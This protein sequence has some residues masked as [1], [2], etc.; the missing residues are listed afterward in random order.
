MIKTRYYKLYGGIGNQLF[1]FAH[2]K[3]LQKQGINIKFILNRN[4]FKKPFFDLPELFTLKNSNII[5]PKNKLSLLCSKFYAK[6]ILR[7]WYAGFYQDFAFAQSL[8]DEKNLGNFEFAQKKEFDAL[9]ITKKID[10]C[11]AVA[12]HIRG[13]DY[14]RP[15]EQAHFGGIC[16]VNYYKNAILH[17]AKNLQNPQFFVFTN[18]LFYAEQMIAQVCSALACTAQ[19]SAS[20]EQVCATQSINTQN[21]AQNLDLAKIIHFVKDT[22]KDAFAQNPALDLYLFT[23]CKGIIMANSTYSFWGAFLNQ[24]NALV[25]TPS[26]WSNTDK[27]AIESLVP[28]QSN[29][30]RI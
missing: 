8:K 26:N 10:C 14:L 29:W 11:N 9:N 6:Y 25:A 27:N 23:K 30:V 3:Y 16:T 24:K 28:K 21:N 1:E 12:I 20:A 4:S 13:G 17:I 18:D 5:V 2:G 15:N 19:N 22:E 7:S